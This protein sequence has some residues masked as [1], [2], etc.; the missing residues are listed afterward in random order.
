MLNN[1]FEVTLEFI[2]KAQSLFDW[3]LIFCLVKITFVRLTLPLMQ[4]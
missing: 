4:L 2:K 3:A 1:F